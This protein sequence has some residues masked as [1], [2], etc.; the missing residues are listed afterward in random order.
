MA[1]IHGFHSP[2]MQHH[3]EGLC[4]EILVAQLLVAIVY[5]RCRGQSKRGHGKSRNSCTIVTQ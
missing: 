3:P 5:R 1:Q 2:G 4:A